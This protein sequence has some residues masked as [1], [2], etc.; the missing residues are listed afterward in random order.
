LYSKL[1]A[2][3]LLEISAEGI[4]SVAS[5]IFAGL[6]FPALDIVAATTE[7][8]NR[9]VIKVV[10]NTCGQKQEVGFNLPAV[11][12]IKKIK[13]YEVS[14]NSIY[15]M[16]TCDSPENVTV[17][18]KELEPEGQGFRYISNPYVS[19]IK[20]S[21][22]IFCPLANRAS[23]QDIVCDFAERQATMV[24]RFPSSGIGAS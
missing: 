17:K 8:G 23:T 18:E 11:G 15:V 14:A 3:N 19:M 16:N 20:T 2:P 13:V 12:K 4:P 22:A 5:Q 21:C 24:G 10:N 9:I 6:T 1:Y 7:S